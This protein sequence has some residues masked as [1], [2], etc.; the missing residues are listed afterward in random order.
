MRVPKV[1]HVVG[2]LFVIPYQ[3]LVID[4]QTCSPMMG[5]PVERNGRLLSIYN[6][7]DD[8]FTMSPE[9][10]TCRL[11]SFMEGEDSVVVYHGQAFQPHLVGKKAG[12]VEELVM[13][14]SADRS[15]A[16]YANALAHAYGWGDVHATV[17]QDHPHIFDYD[18]DQEVQ[19]ENAMCEARLKMFKDALSG[20]IEILDWTGD[21]MVKPIFD[22]M[23]VEEQIT[24]VDDDEGIKDLA[25]RMVNS[26]PKELS[27]LE[28]VSVRTY[29]WD[30]RAYDG[31]VL[32]QIPLEEG[33]EVMIHGQVGS[34]FLFVCMTSDSRRATTS[35]VEVENLAYMME[36]IPV[37]R[38][39]LSSCDRKTNQAWFHARK[40]A[41][42]VEEGW[43]RS[44]D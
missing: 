15:D 38:D 5:G 40:A 12:A 36:W 13:T 43:S 41:L 2:D 10:V 26:L 4:G 31:G 19:H 39:S 11:Q 3:I 16:Q 44:D 32:V 42:R 23:S 18:D 7:T 17:E 14:L 1:F 30:F 24:R 34:D 21:L 27:E 33:V 8:W 20:K 29:V 9:D 28:G 25:R 22:G 37:A 35:G 6:G